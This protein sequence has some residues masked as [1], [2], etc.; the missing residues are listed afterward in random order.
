MF[1]LL[2]DMPNYAKINTSALAACAV[3]KDQVNIDSK[4]SSAKESSTQI[5][6]EV[7]L[8]YVSQTPEGIYLYT[9]FSYVYK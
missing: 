2:P 7:V 1:S 4:M 8:V 6:K 9:C 5:Q 3:Q